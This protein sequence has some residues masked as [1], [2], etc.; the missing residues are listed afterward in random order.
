[1]RWV[2]AWGAGGW[3][4]GWLPGWLNE[5]LGGD[6]S[7][8]WSQA[9][10]HEIWGKKMVHVDTFGQSAELGQQTPVLLNP[11]TWTNCILP[12]R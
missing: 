3:E 12:S 5:H 9:G 1:M 2:G 7:R 8:L 4:G 10:N 6:G 11:D